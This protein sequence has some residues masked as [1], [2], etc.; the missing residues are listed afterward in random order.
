MRVGVVGRTTCRG[1]LPALERVL[2][3]VDAIVHAGELGPAAV[4][5]RLATLAP[6][7]A[8]VGER[9]YLEWGDRFPEL[10]EVEFAGVRVLV[11]HMIGTPPDLLPAIRDRLEDDP[12]GVVVHGHVPAA[13]VAWI[14]GT[15]FVAPGAACPVARDRAGT[16]AVLQ[17]APGG[18][19]TAEVHELAAPRAGVS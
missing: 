6:L 8:V 15:L 4:V 16:C 19:V 1:I 7:T 5:E 10:A 9:D 13:R 11:T 14:G 2:A 3:G 18:R 12:P 17:V